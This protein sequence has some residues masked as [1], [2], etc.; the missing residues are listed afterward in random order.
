MSIPKNYYLDNKII[1]NHRIIQ[2]RPKLLLI[3]NVCNKADNSDLVT[4]YQ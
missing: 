4:P 2:Y 1:I 3:T